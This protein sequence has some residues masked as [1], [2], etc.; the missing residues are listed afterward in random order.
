MKHECIGRAATSKAGR[1]RGRTFLIVG[2]LDDNHVYLADGET[3]KLAAPKKKKL[4]HLRIEAKTAANI[5][6]KLIEGGRVLDAEIRSSLQTLGYNTEP[7]H[8]EG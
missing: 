1:D 3:R 6:E 5:H 4:K 8:Q 2:V 7:E